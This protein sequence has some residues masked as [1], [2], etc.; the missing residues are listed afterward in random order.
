MKK[1]LKDIK[2]ALI[3]VRNKQSAKRAKDVDSSQVKNQ[4]VIDDNYLGLYSKA[5]KHDA[6]TM[7][8]E[9]SD[10]KE[11]QVAVESGE[12]S[13]FDDIKLEGARKQA[14]PQGCLSSEL[15]GGD[16]EGFSMKTAPSLNSREAAA[17]M[18]EVYLKNIM[19]DKPFKDYEDGSQEITDAL[20]ILNAFGSD[21]KGPKAGGVVTAKTLFRGITPGCELG[22]YISQLFL[23]EIG[24]GNFSYEPK[25]P[26]KTGVY[27]NTQANYVDIQD[28]NVPVAQT[29]DPVKKFMF[30]GRQLGSTVH[31]DLVFQHF[32]EAAAILLNNGATVGSQVL[33]GSKEGNFLGGPVITTT[34]IAEVSRHALR[35]AWVQK[36]RKH[37][38]LRPEAMAARAVAEKA[39]SIAGGT[40]HADLLSSAVIA[41]V[42][43]FNM[44]NG[45]EQKALLPLQYAEGSP[46]HPAYP[47]GHA[48]I[49]GACATILKI[50]FADAAWSSLGLGE[51]QANDDGSATE[52]YSGSDK[53]AAAPGDSGTTIHNEINKL[54]HNVAIGRNYAGV[55]YRSDSELNLGEKIA[56]QYYK[57]QKAL[58]N[59]EIADVTIVKFDGTSE[60]V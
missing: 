58:F 36:W 25:G 32:Y 20:A 56:I 40:V 11:I 10:I 12:Q 42:E 1:D 55:H 9:E 7:L 52:A 41:M 15:S 38:R 35:G 5:L 39:G 17:E 47:A 43:N 6:V 44:A 23:N 30:N 59:E 37:L 51:I 16:P 28:G 45:G 19:R 48:T 29:I 27:G 50:M 18:A 8:A 49:A 26:T 31:I 60:T 21:F 14:S 22:G 4:D 34:A 24:V 33:V 13:D 3:N 46:T 2:R 54:A 53:D 57:D